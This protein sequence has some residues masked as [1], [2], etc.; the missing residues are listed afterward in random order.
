[1]AVLIGQSIDGREVEQ[2]T[3]PW[4]PERFASMC[5]ALAWAA[6]GHSCP[7]LPSFTSRVNAK[8]GGI[9]AEWSVEIP[10]TGN[11]IPTPMI[12]PGWNV[13]QYKKRDL[14]AQ[15]RR[16]VISNLKASL[17]NAVQDIVTRSKGCP[18]HYILFVNV[19]L[20]HDDKQGFRDAIL[21]GLPDQNL[22]VEIIGAGE[23]AALL[24]NHPHLRAAYFTERLFKTWETA[25][26]DHQKHK[27]FTPNVELTGREEDLRRLKALVD[28]PHVQAL[29]LSGPHDVG[30]SRLTLEA[31]RHR[32]HDTVF[33]LDPRSTDLGDY[34]SLYTNHG[35]VICIIE[36]PEPDS[37]EDLLNEALVAPHFKIIITL[38]TTA[39]APAPSYGR[40]ERI[41]SLFLSPLTSEDA[42]RLLRAVEQPLD[43][44]VEDW[45]LRHAG[46]IPGILLAAASV[47]NDLRT[48]FTNFAEAVGREFEKRIEKELGPDALT[49]VRLLSVLTHVGVAGRVENE[50]RY[51]C[52][53]FGEG[54]TPNPVLLSLPQLE[55]AGLVKR[56]GLF[57][58]V[59]LPLLA[60][61]LVTQLLRGRRL[62]ML[63][64]F[65]KLEAPGQVRFLR[66]LSEM[67]S[68]EVNQ[69][70]DAMFA[71][72]GPFSDWQTALTNL[73]LLQIIAGAVPEHVLHLLE[74]GLLNSTREERLAIA[75]GQRRELMWTLEE[76]LFR[77]KTSRSAARLVWLLT[78]AEN[79]TCGNNATGVLTSCFHPLH[80]QMPLTLRQR[81]ILLSEFL[82][83]GISRE[84]KPVATKIVK[85]SFEQNGW[86]LLRSSS[87][88][89]PFEGR[90][91]FT[92]EELHDYYSFLVSILFTFAKD[93]DEIATAALQALPAAIEEFGGS[94]DPAEAVLHFR[95]L[96][97]WA[98]AGKAYLDVS[99]LSG[100]LRRLRDR[101]SSFLEESNFPPGRRGEFTDYVAQ[102][103]QLKTELETANF[104]TCLK[105]WAGS[106]V[107]EDEQELASGGSPRFEEQLKKLAEEAVKNPDLL[108]TE[109]IEWLLS[110]AA[111]RPDGF[112]FFLGKCDEGTTFRELVEQLE[113]RGNGTRLFAAYWRGWA[114]ADYSGASRRLD[115]LVAIN[116]V[117]GD[118]IVF[119]TTYLGVSPQAV[120]RMKAQIQAKRI[121]P[122]SVRAALLVG[123][124]MKQLTEEQFGQLL[125]Q[126]TGETFEH[127]SVA[128]DLFGSWIHNERSLQGDLAHFAWVCLEHAPPVKPPVQERAF[129]LLAA[130]LAEGDLSRGFRLLTQLLQGKERIEGFGVDYW[131]PLN[132]P[133]TSRLWNVLYAKD[134]EQ[135]FH[136]LLEVSKENSLQGFYLPWRV[137]EFINQE[138][139]KELFLSLATCDVENARIL[140]GWITSAK[141]GFWPIVFAF[142][143]MYPDD[144]QMLNKLTSGIEQEGVI[145]EGPRSRFY[146]GRKQEI[147]QILND[148][149]APVEV[150][151]WLREILNR[152]EREIPRQLVWEYDI[153]VDE[154]RHHVQDKDSPQRIWAIGRILK[155]AEW[156]D[157]R[158]LLTVEDI[159][160]A[161]PQVDLPD[162]K[163]RELERLVKVWKHGQ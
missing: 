87:G 161:L 57:A 27:R 108:S 75:G 82:S 7:S 135:L 54:W 21:K 24:N 53:L 50:L 103:D 119:A 68:E 107:Y 13:F 139:D 15:D 71:A 79:E 81:K 116:L 113:Q 153:D 123:Q 147:V 80:P 159:E 149:T 110:P 8:D 105:R 37:V 22:H 9:D 115:E 160:E 93:E 162:K 96:V 33:A 26:Q 30:K 77:L 83:E 125:K 64:L 154:L 130:K 117:T 127:A 63:A 48:E 144:E 74:Q 131:H 4:S 140:A 146:E 39:N 46:G 114:E 56:G 97:D 55:R 106:W 145:R 40:D 142:V 72:D 38:P 60:N 66:R 20:K 118:A 102:A 19:D 18:D 67:Q 111:E 95:T 78:E 151:T 121:A 92:Y 42:R 11:A 150:R 69:F 25:Y 129:D 52:E 143:Q 49:C 148:P 124:W 157:T 59:T 58:E 141:P 91:S 109:L 34:R 62:E 94:T 65:G 85:R 133:R 89:E 44:E 2:E 35:E 120:E 86:V 5:D 16:R 126:I 136:I 134:R 155:Y 90:P 101:L 29:V 156:K 99:S 84:G 43:Y 61:R 100:A 6:S 104:T 152:V 88:P 41:Q 122:V 158:R 12:G 47:G 132:H 23:L 36:D 76:L 28:D 31:T 32:P 45:I 128:I 51:I 10:S 14:I 112:F 98:R 138:E 1:M 70:W 17:K 137:R 73:H 163:R 3:S